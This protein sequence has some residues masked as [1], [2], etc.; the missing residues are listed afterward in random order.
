MTMYN[1]SNRIH[2]RKRPLAAAVAL[3]SGSLL[4]GLAQA[5][6]AASGPMLE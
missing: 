4:A 1:K 2:S 6:P 3:C 5:Q